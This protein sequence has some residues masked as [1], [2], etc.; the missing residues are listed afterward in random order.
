[1]P[2]SENVAV[3]SSAAG[4]PKITVPGPLVLLHVFVTGVKP[5]SVT[6]PSRLVDAEPVTG[7]LI[8]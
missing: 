4:L 5:S 8:A 7:K 2:G 3:V 1:V 6:V